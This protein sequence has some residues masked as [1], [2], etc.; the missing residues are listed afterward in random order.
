MR[1]HGMRSPNEPWSFGAEVEE[2]LVEYI[3]LRK[4]LQ[5]YLMEQSKAVSKTGIPLVRPLWLEFPEDDTCT[6]VDDQYLLGD[7]LLVAPVTGEGERERTVVFPAGDTWTDVWQGT[8]YEGGTT[9]VVPAL[10][11]QIPV[12]F[13]GSEDKP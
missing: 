6:G 11:E 10:L 1:M 13:R 9:Q 2:I 3:H 4:N 5:H 7:H 8:T 12:F